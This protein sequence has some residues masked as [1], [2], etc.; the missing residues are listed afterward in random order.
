MTP[1]PRLDADPQQR[2]SPDLSQDSGRLTYR[3]GKVGRR[4]ELVYPE[5][6][7]KASEA[8]SYALFAEMRVYSVQVAFNIREFTYTLYYYDSPPDGT[9]SGVLVEKGGQ[10]IAQFRCDEDTID[11]RL[12]ELDKIG[13]PDHKPRDLGIER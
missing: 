7:M 6:P 3:F 2:S 9:S 10:R 1:N 5:V 11:G 4:P 12:V 8:Y 13:P